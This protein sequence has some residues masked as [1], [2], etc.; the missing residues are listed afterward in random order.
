MLLY[1]YCL[2]YRNHRVNKLV[3]PYERA[4]DACLRKE[5]IVYRDFQN[6]PRKH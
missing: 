3:I 5:R 4:L 1:F 6:S 2:F